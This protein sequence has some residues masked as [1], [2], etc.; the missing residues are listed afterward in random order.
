MELANTSPDGLPWDH[1]TAHDALRYSQKAS[2]TLEYGGI[3]LTPPH[4][5][6]QSRVESN[7]SNEL[8]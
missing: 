1:H 2:Q 7:Q 5:M 4:C 8:G 6:R 3:G